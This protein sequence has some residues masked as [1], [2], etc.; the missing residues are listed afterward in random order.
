MELRDYLHILRAQ[1]V[2]IA[3]VTLIGTGTGL[4]VTLLTTPQYEA[5]AK[6]YVSVRSDSQ[7]SGDLLQG[8]NFARQNM[9]TFV[10][11]ATTTRVLEPV[12]DQL[13][14]GIS[15]TQLAEKID[16][17]APDDSTMMH[18]AVI[19][20]NPV[21]AAEIANE[22]GAQTRNLVEEDLEPAQDSASSPVSIRMV[23]PAEVPSVPVSPRPQLNLIMGVL[24]GLALGVGLAIL[25][26]FLDTRIR[27]TE[28][29][30]RITEAPVLGRIAHDPKAHRKPL[31]VHLDPR[32]PRAEAFRTLRTNIKF[33]AVGE[34]PKTF[35]VSSAG[36]AEGKTTTS[37]NLALAL[38]ETGLRV[39]LV[40]CDLRRPQVADYMGI[41]GSV[42]VTDILIGHAELSDV[43][44]R[45]GRTKL[46]VLPSG[47]LPPNPSEL[48]GSEAMDQILTQLEQSTD[49]IILDAPPVLLVTDAVVIGAKTQGV[50]F[51]AAAGTTKKPA[52]EAA[53]DSLDVAGVPL[54]GLVATMLPT[55]GAEAH[56]YGTYAYS[57]SDTAT[58][59]SSWFGNL[60]RI[61]RRSRGARSKD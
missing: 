42:G 13:A 51:V 52:L 56:R 33:L 9:V 5:Q 54:R 60:R 55:K 32:S 31:I 17:S 10:E 14:L 37:I 57:S 6:L 48:L 35:V 50:I 7:A 11:L 43:L 28:D 15:T 22:V 27:S 59:R 23:E 25:R 19:D 24:L 4:A 18:V 58:E 8:S 12:A 40:D 39:A 1:W 21:Q 46:D 61:R 41:E 36:P 49:V 38:A 26:T 16:V 53:I 30:A 44:Q 47:Q 20:E 29:I 45:W 3:L 2:L 34:G